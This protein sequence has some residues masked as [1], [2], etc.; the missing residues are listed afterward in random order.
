[1]KINFGIPRKTEKWPIFKK[2]DIWNSG[3]NQTTKSITLLWMFFFLLLFLFAG[4]EIFGPF[5]NHAPYRILFGFVK[6]ILTNHLYII[7]V[8]F[9]L[10]LHRTETV[11]TYESGRTMNKQTSR[12]SKPLEKTLPLLMLY[13]VYTPN[14]PI[15][16]N[17]R[18]AVDSFMRYKNSFNGIPNRKHENKSCYGVYLTCRR[19]KINNYTLAFGVWMVPGGMYA[20]LCAIVL[21]Q[22]QNRQERARVFF[23]FIL[24][25]VISVSRVAEAVYW[26]RFSHMLLKE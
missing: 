18:S 25:R 20:V 9:F 8:Y 23:S 21:R 4:F 7:C 24:F 14:V 6:S 13:C 17:I 15:Y 19:N 12:W 5:R 1:M 22:S 11:L 2:M 26:H 16:M 3:K 10:K